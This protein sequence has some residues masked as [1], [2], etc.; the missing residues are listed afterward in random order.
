MTSRDTV[1]AIFSKRSQVC[2][3]KSRVEN[4]TGLKIKCFRTDNGGEFTSRKFETL[5][6]NAS[7]LHQKTA[8]YTP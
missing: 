1:G 5:L 7:I 6:K 4:E 2:L 8:P 3:S